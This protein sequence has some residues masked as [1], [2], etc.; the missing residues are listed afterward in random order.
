MKNLTYEA[1]LTDPAVLKQIERDARRARAEA[2]Y[3][4]I[5]VPLKSMLKRALSKT[6]G[7]AQQIA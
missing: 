5:V 3:R 1:C 6:V 7:V 2:V 4:Y